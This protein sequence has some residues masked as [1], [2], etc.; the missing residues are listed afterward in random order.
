MCIYAPLS[1]NYE[2]IAIHSGT[3]QYSTFLAQALMGRIARK[4]FDRPFVLLHRV[5]RPALIILSLGLF[6]YPLFLTFS[7][8][9]QPIRRNAMIEKRIFNRIIIL[10]FGNMVLNP[11]EMFF[12]NPNRRAEF[13]D[14]SETASDE[15]YVRIETPSFSSRQFF[16]VI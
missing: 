13:R 2:S 11:G 4:E 14:K 5:K 3:R 16:V 8:L 12:L 10:I 1:K 9:R 7:E 6:L 15:F